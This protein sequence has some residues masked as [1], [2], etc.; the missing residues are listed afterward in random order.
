MK[1]RTRIVATDDLGH[2]R[3]GALGVLEAQTHPR[4]VLVRWDCGCREYVRRDNIMEAP[5]G[6][7]PAPKIEERV[8]DPLA[9]Y[10]GG[11]DFRLPTTFARERARKVAEEQEASPRTTARV[12]SGDRDARRPGG[13]DLSRRP[14][15]GGG[16]AAVPP[17]RRSGPPRVWTEEKIVAALK[18]AAVDG[19]APSAQSWRHGAPGR[20]PANTVRRQFGSWEAA[21]A[22]A[23][24]QVKIPA[25]AI[26][27]DEAVAEIRRWASITGAAPSFSD[28][29]PV[30]ARKIGREDIAR[31]FE[32]APDGPWPNAKVVQRLFGGWGSALRAAGLEP[33]ANGA[34][35]PP[36][37]VPDAA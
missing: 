21:A 10:E 1:R 27:R 32:D 25:P 19:V 35:R 12:L 28:W 5:A 9:P 8:I 13:A 14:S 16:S 24:L 37:E 15:R 20:P 18:A 2:N 17:P 7:P 3:T 6:S 31:R 22:A 11:P 4:V 33:R 23:G 26:T 29:E 34:R 36:V 30:M